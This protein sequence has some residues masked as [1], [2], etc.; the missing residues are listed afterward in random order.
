M[1]EKLKNDMLK[2]RLKMASFII[3][4]KKTKPPGK[5]LNTTHTR[6]E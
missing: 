1:K 2:L 4:P 6:P 5:T 3:T